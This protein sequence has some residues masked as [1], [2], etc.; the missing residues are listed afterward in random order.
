MQRYPGSLGGSGAFA[1][2]K[3]FDGS[4]VWG[5]P[6]SELVSWWVNDFLFSDLAYGLRGRVMIV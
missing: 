6:R 5:C 4:K 2:A 1:P 3:A